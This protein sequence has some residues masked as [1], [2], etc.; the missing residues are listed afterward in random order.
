MVSILRRHFDPALQMVAELVDGCPASIWAAQTH[1]NP[2]WQHVM[3]ALIGAEFWFR[4]A[5]EPFAPPDLGNGPVPDLDKIPSFELD[6]DSARSY[7]E[8]IR[9]RT[10]TFFGSLD[11]RRLQS[12]SS[13]YEKCTYAD[14]ILMQT[15]HM[16][17]H[18]GYCNRLLRESGCA[19]AKWLGYAE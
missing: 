7:L 4:E 6:R 9:A 13:I 18:V 11:D 16:Q 17:H 3:H 10:E 15:R 5:S 12:P 14:L 19:T 1:G 2:F 8:R